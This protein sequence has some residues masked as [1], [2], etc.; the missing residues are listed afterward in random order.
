MQTRFDPTNSEHTRVRVENQ[1]RYL[2]TCWLAKFA[3]LFWLACKRANQLGF[4][5]VLQMKMTEINDRRRTGHQKNFVGRE[6]SSTTTLSLL[7][8]CCCC[9][10]PRKVCCFQRSMKLTGSVNLTGF[11]PSGV[12]ISSPINLFWEVEWES[13][14]LSELVF[15]RRTL[16]RQGKAPRDRNTLLLLQ[17]GKS[18]HGEETQS[19]YRAAG[20]ERHE[21]QLLLSTV[22]MAKEEQT[23][24]E[25]DLFSARRTNWWRTDHEYHEGIPPDFSPSSQVCSNLVTLLVSKVN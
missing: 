13:V 5:C 2:R 12:W 1:Q 19:S 16:Y 20:Q 6:S 11:T 22:S 3:S 10:A 25:K 4:C 24:G 8:C 23:R 7:L 21:R 9:W 15:I 14:L 18:L 17:E